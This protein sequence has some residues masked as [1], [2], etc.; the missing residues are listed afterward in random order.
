MRFL[1]DG[2]LDAL[3]RVDELNVDAS[4]KR[5]P[6]GKTPRDFPPKTSLQGPDKPTNISGPVYT[7]ELCVSR[8]EEFALTKKEVRIDQSTCSVHVLASI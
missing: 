4:S 2:W 7:K 1:C 6:S 8:A 3:G 5:L